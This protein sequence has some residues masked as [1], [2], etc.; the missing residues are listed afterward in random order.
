MSPNFKGFVLGLAA[1]LALFA[2]VASQAQDSPPAP[3]AVPVFEIQKDDKSVKLRIGSLPGTERFR[4]HSCVSYAGAPTALCFIIDLSNMTAF[5]VQV[6]TG[7]T[8]T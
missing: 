6:N 4:P 7:E 3:V 8:E 1:A 2:C 5:T